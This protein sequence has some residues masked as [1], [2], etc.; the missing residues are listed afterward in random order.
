M[1]NVNVL[2]LRL[3]VYPVTRESSQ[4]VFN[5]DQNIPYFLRKKTINFQHGISG[6]VGKKSRR[7]ESCNFRADSCKYVPQ[8]R[9]WVLKISTF[10][11][12]FLKMSGF[13]H[14]CCIFGRKLSNKK[15]IFRQP[16]FREGAIALRRKTARQTEREGGKR[17]KSLWKNPHGHNPKQNLPPKGHI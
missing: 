5:T 9:S 3:A 15:K 2:F 13:G 4:F 16:K 7:A 6:V 8:R 1:N 10:P 14:K 17:T 11:L 12:N